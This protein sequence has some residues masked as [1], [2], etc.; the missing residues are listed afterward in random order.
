[1]Q[2]AAIASGP[3]SPVIRQANTVFRPQIVAGIGGLIPDCDRADSLVASEV[4][5]RC[6]SLNTITDDSKHHPGYDNGPGD[7]EYHKRFRIC[8][9][10][11]PTLWLGGRPFGRALRCNGL[12]STGKKPF[13]NV[14]REFNEVDLRNSRFGSKDEPVGFD[15]ANRR[16]FVYLA[17][18]RFEVLSHRDRCEANDQD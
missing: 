1:M 4:V 12:R 5:S 10:R 14:F 18:D 11:Y 17:I 15:T 13:L 9:R 3:G 16:V 8:D 6:L 7:E 2:D